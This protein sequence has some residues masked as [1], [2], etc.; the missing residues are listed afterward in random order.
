MDM[1]VFDLFKIGIGPSSS[2]T[3]G[4]M[5][6]ARRFLVE[7]GSLEDAVGVEAHLYGSLALTGVGHATDKAVILGLMGETPQDVD[8]D[9]VEDKLAEAELDGV[10]NLLGVKPVPFTCGT[11][12]VWHKQ[13]TL[14]EHPNG[15]RFV[16]KLADGSVIER[17]YYSIGGGFI[18]APGETQ[19]ARET[20]AVPFPFSTMRELL[21]QGTRDGL[22]IPAML[23]A[24]ECARMTNDALDTGLDRI[25]EVMRG[26]IDH[27]L[28]TEGEL[29][30][31][32]NVKRR[33]AKLWRQEQAAR[34]ATNHLPHDAVNQVSLYAM[35]VNEENA[36]GGRVV[37]AP[38][39]G[40]AGIIPAVLR[41]YA[42]DCRP[43]DAR[44]GIHDFLLTAAAIGMLCKKNASISGAEIG[45]QGEVGVACAMAAAG[46][47]A[48]L[49]GSNGQIENAAEI[50]I[51]HH[52][53][54]TCDPIGGLVQIPC[55]E[56]NGMGAI[57]AITAASLAM[58]GDGTHFVSLDDVIETMRQTG[59]D[60][61]AKYKETS[62]GGLA[63]HVV[64]V[65]H[66][67]C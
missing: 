40:A 33:A 17:I 42:E 28:V 53:G 13:S 21:E 58:K 20:V 38:T 11:G 4:P 65:N 36:A 5:V 62:L 44:R 56:R 7:C 9:S 27:G 59:F 15:M 23:R 37:T 51:E 48:A 39:N 67:A 49:G 35:A 46:L 34:H 60:M 31:G 16:L 41:Y 64:T 18:T 6:A 57:K 43:S 52:L 29:P 19:A 3:V 26:C 47:V 25:W 50:G 61:Q 24:N 22:T 1:S 54:M 63:I 66:A 32:L 30:G 55:I 8:P 14:P 10:L 45:C 2:H 12:L